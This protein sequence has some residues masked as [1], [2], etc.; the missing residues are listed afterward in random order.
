MKHLSLRMFVAP[1]YYFFNEMYRHLRVVYRLASRITMQAVESA[2]QLYCKF[3][4]P[5]VETRYPFT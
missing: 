2:R 4:L 3:A 5:G 1:L